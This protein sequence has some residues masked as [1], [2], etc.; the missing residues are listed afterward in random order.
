MEKR[1][2]NNDLIN[3]LKSYDFRINKNATSFYK[4]V[5]LKNKKLK[6]RV[7]NHF[8]HIDKKK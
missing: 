3:L 1:K 5:V 2:I 8:I 4:T 7:S 6:I